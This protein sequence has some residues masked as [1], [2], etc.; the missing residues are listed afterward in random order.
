VVPGDTAR[1]SRMHGNNP[2]KPCAFNPLNNKRFHLAYLERDGACGSPSRL[3]PHEPL[4]RSLCEE[5]SPSHEPPRTFNVQ[6]P[7]SNNRPTMNLVAA[8]VR[9]LHLEF[10]TRR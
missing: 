6:R 2:A 4:E 5:S 3:Q 8:E 1:V 9:R 7:T 10:M